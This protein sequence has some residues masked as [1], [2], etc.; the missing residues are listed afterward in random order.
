M[1]KSHKI[2]CLV[3][4]C[5]SYLFYAFLDLRL[6]AK[7]VSLFSIFLPIIFGFYA[8]ALAVLFGTGAPSK[9]DRL[10]DPFVK[11]SSRLG[12][13]LSYYKFAGSVAIVSIITIFFYTLDLFYTIA[14]EL[15]ISSFYSMYLVEHLNY[16]LLSLLSINFYSFI[17]LNYIFINTLL[18]SIRVK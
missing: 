13:L 6:S 10:P 2:L 14:I 4:V 1:R 17:I 11:G 3:I 8:T 16:I 18:Y 9:L 7:V 15:R 5:L 12:V